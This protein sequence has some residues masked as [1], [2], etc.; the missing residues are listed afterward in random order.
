MS[1]LNQYLLLQGADGKQV[2]LETGDL[3]GAAPPPSSCG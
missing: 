2:G 3:S 1:K